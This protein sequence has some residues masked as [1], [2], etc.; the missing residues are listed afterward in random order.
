M[1]IGS[2]RT[3]AAKQGEGIAAELSSKQQ[4]GRLRDE[5]RS[6]ELRILFLATLQM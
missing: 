5:L 2:F 1:I 4:D 3:D 6:Q